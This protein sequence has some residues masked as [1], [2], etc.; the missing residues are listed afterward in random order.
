VNI[1]G[2]VSQHELID[3]YEVLGLHCI[4]IGE[5]FCPFLISNAREKLGVTMKESEFRV[6]FK[7]RLSDKCRCPEHI[8]AMKIYF[9]TRKL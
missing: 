3:P 1:L 4:G 6:R 8:E 2:G 9:N 7:N 5:D